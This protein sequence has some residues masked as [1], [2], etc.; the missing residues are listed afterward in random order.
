ME[1]IPDH[2]FRT[3]RNVSLICCPMAVA[4]SSRGIYCLHYS[5]HSHHC[6]ETS[7]SQ[8]FLSILKY[9]ALGEVHRIIYCVPISTNYVLLFV[10]TSSNKDLPLC[11]SLRLGTRLL[12]GNITASKCMRK[13][14]KCRVSKPVFIHRWNYWG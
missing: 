4:A 10:R 9:Q 1:C 13:V 8:N 5:Y 12:A 11:T 3:E 2:V 14:V 7:S 6:T